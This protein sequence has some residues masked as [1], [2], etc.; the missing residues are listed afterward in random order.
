MTLST[1][2]LHGIHH[3]VYH[4]SRTT[5]VTGF[6]KTRLP[7]TSN[8]ST[9]IASNLTTQ[10]AIALQFSHNAVIALCNNKSNFETDSSRS[11]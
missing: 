8:S 4:Y 6:D 7:H 2:N 10:Y 1:I 11:Y 5:F 3:C 9:L